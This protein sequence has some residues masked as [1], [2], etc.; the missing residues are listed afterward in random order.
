MN[1]MD[2]VEKIVSRGFATLTKEEFTYKGK[3]YL[4]C[5]VIISPLLL[6]GVNC[7]SGCGGCCRRFTLDWLPS[8][9]SKVK[10]EGY[11]MSRVKER[12]IQFNGREVPVLSDVQDDHDGYWCRNLNP[13]DGRCGIH[14]FSPLSCDFELIRTIQTRPDLP[15]RLTQKLFGRGWAM[16]RIVDGERGSMCSM[17]PPTPDTIASVVRRLN[18]FKTWTDHFGIDTYIPDILHCIETRALY[19]HQITMHPPGTQPK[20]FGL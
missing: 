10:K 7:P 9:R 4:P 18:R 1:L 12:M 8:E 15:N 17:T 3:P 6:R 14:T 2:S 20:G 5:T 19:Q 13:K 16:K 11:D